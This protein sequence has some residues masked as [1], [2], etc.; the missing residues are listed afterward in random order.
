M[1]GSDRLLAFSYPVSAFVHQVNRATAEQ[2][3]AQA[4]KEG[5]EPVKQWFNDLANEIIEREFNSDEIEF[6]WAEEDEID[7]KKQAEILTSYAD[8]GA[9]TLNEVRERIGEEPS[10]DPAAGVLAVKTANG[11]VPI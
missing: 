2:H 7:Q 10:P 9:M 6:A 5:L 3:E 8:S 1:V 4:E 11:R